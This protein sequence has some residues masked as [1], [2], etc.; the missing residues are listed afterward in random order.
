MVLVIG[1]AIS[2]LSADVVVR[3]GSTSLVNPS[4]FVA[5]LPCMGLYPD[6]MLLMITC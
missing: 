5:V 1:P 3:T 2:P 4:F 6:S